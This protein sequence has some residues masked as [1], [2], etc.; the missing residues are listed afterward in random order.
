MAGTNDI[1]GNTGPS[2]LQDYKNNILAMLDLAKAHGI[3]VILAGIPPCRLIFGIRLDPRRRIGE[4]NAWLAEV[5]TQRKLLFLDYG[6]VLAG[7]DAGMKETLSND[8]V[9]PTRAGYA[10][11]MPM[12][13]RA[14]ADALGGGR[15]NDK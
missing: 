9:H 14:L 4:I 7:A 12:L 6:T 13:E 5:A 1:G 10:R 2:T 8:G 11:M 3:K 15:R